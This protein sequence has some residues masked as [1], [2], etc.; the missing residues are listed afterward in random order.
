MYFDN[1]LSGWHCGWKFLQIFEKNI[2]IAMR[3]LLNPSL[4]KADF[5]SHEPLR[6]EGY[7]FMVYL[8]KLGFITVI[9]DLQVLRTL[10]DI[11]PLALAQNT[12]F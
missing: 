10:A 4:C 3:I 2:N 9:A 11:L 8:H 6:G 5:F 12:A 7:L 1:N